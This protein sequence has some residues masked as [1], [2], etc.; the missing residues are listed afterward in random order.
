MYLV[1][2][3]EEEEVQDRCPE[4]TGGCPGAV[5]EDLGNITP[6]Y[7]AVP[8]GDHGSPPYAGIPVHK[9]LPAGFRRI[10]TAG[11]PEQPD[12]VFAGLRVWIDEGIY[13]R[14][15]RC[16]FHPPQG[17]P[18]LSCN[19]HTGTGV[20]VSRCPA[21]S[22]EGHHRAVPDVPVRVPE[23]FFKGRFCPFVPHL[24]Q[25]HGSNKP[26]LVVPV[27]FKSLHYG[28]NRPRAFYIAQRLDSAEAD[29]HPG[30]V[31][32]G[33]ERIAGRFPQGAQCVC[34]PPLGVR[35]PVIEQPDETSYIPCLFQ[36]FGRCHLHP[37][38]LKFTASASTTR[39]RG[40]PQERRSRQGSA[41]GFPQGFRQAIQTYRHW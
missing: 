33:D 36:Y 9:R 13:E 30:K 39:S 38:F 6:A 5:R 8:A 16:L 34:S 4:G 40:P 1:P 2:E 29:M 25:C 23:G 15:D 19:K 27:V 10:L 22:F 31:K 7:P 41:A 14:T 35:A 20:L 11:F 24:A 28:F 12:N 37:K 32:D 21:G 3:T 26:D 18:F 17:C